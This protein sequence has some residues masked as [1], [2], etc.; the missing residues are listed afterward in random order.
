MVASCPCLRCSCKKKP[1][2]WRESEGLVTEL[3]SKELLQYSDC[4]LSCAMRLLQKV[5]NCLDWDFS[6]SELDVWLPA[7]QLADVRKMWCT[8]ERRFVVHV[9]L[10]NPFPLFLVGIPSIQ[11]IRS[12][13][14]LR[15][16]VSSAISALNGGIM[17]IP[18]LQLQKKPVTCREAEGLV[19]ELWS[20]ELLQYSDC[21]VSCAMRL[22]P[23]SEQ[24]SRLRF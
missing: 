15:A 2:I 17:P 20:K 7:F 1:V 24:L 11:P 13:R 16:A 21:A 19:T 3:W 4:A 8:A 10:R 23:T 5:N 9:C 6:N 18:S 22:L 14:F 12:L